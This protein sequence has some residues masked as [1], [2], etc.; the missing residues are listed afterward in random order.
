MFVSPG[1]LKQSWRQLGKFLK[2]L[3][4][5]SGKTEFQMNVY[6]QLTD[7]LCAN[8]DTDRIEIASAVC[9]TFMKLFVANASSQQCL[10]N[11]DK[12]LLA[13]I[14]SFIQVCSSFD[15]YSSSSI[16]FYLVRG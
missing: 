15:L 10:L 14:S 6:C 7:I 3:K 5:L 13:P 16:G 4:S 2:K 8:S 9:I 1:K 12:L 11:V